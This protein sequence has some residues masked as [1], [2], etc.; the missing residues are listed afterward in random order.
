MLLGKPVIKG[1]RLSVEFIMSLLAGGWD[2]KE[3]LRNYPG[4][5]YEDIL[6]CLQYATEVLGH[7][8]VFPIKRSA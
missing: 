3:I 2:E 1:S 6:A 7:E 8:S 5:T 4:L